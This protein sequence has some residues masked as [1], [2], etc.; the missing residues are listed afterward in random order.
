MD[1]QIQTS[2]DEQ[3]DLQKELQELQAQLRETSQGYTNEQLAIEI[4]NQENENEALQKDLEGFKA[5][6]I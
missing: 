5:G 3:A 6:S 1:E 4:E 2:K